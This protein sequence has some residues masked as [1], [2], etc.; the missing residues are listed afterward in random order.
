MATKQDMTGMLAV[1]KAG[2]DRT[3]IYV[4]VREE[5]EYVYLAD[6]R[7]AEEKKQ[8]ACSGY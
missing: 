4:I 6:R 3:E 5:D 2:H 1:S 8:K 7:K